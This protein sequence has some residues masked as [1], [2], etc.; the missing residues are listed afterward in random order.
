MLIH[1]TILILLNII[2]AYY[3]LYIIKGAN[4]SDIINNRKWH[5]WSGWFAMGFALYIGYCTS[6]YFLSGI[7][8]SYRA[9]IFPMYLNVLREKPLFYLSRAGF[10]GKFVEKNLQWVYYLGGF[11]FIGI[12]N[13]FYKHYG[14]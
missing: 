8:L 4:L 9:T 14:Y 7:Y 5:Q 11:F 1:N 6:N 12:L 2:D 3:N 10:E 13:Y